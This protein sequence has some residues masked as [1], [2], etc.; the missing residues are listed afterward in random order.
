MFFAA[1]VPSWIAAGATPG[2]GAPSWM[3]NARSPATKISGCPGAERSGCT[4]T[5]PALSSGTP[6]DF[7]SGDAALP[8]AQNTVRQGMRSSPTYTASGSNA[9]HERIRAHLHAELGEEAAGRLGDLLAEG[10]EQARSALEQDRA[11]APRVDVMELIRHGVPRHLRQDARELHAGGSAADDHERHER[12]LLR[13][14]GALL[15][16][17]ERQQETPADLA[18]I[19]ERLEPRRERFPF[20]MPEVRVARARRDDQIVVRHLE[21][22]AIR[23]HHLP[24]RVDPADVGEQHGDVLLLAQQPPDGRRDL[25]RREHGHRHLVEQRREGVVVVAVEDR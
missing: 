12:L 19:R 16:V 23:D 11:C 9:R 5:R 24:R 17:L 21:R 10:G 3:R 6:S 15:R 25:A 13:C 7:A 14:V 1:Q 4:S 20:G 8:A 2:I 18:R 22:A